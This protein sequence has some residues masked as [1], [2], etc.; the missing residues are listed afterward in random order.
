ME[1]GMFRV[2]DKHMKS[3]SRIDGDGTCAKN[4]HV[5]FKCDE[6]TIGIQCFSLRMESI[7]DLDSRNRLIFFMSYL[8]SM[9]SN[10]T[11]LITTSTSSSSQSNPSLQPVPLS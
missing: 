2:A 11:P 6:K 9:Q 7:R 4:M 3:G 8:I 5:D 1:R 10:C